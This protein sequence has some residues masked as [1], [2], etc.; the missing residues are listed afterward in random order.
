MKTYRIKTKI[1]SLLLSFIPLC[2]WAN[3][4]EID[5]ELKV[6]EEFTCSVSSFLDYSKWNGPRHWRASSWLTIVAEG[7][8]YCKIRADQYVSGTLQVVCDWQEINSST[9]YE[10][11]RRVT[12]NITLKKI[13]VSS[14]SLQPLIAIYADESEN[15]TPG[16]Q[17]MTIY[18]SNATV[19]TISWTSTN[20]DVATI[21]NSGHLVGKKPGTTTIYCMVNGDV[22][23]NDATVQVQEPPFQFNGFSIADQSNNVETKPTITATYSLDLTRSGNFDQIALTDEQGKKVD[24]TVS[25]NGKTLSFTPTKHLQP[26]SAYTL[27]IPKGAVKN[28]WGTDYLFEQKVS[29]ATA[30]WQR[31]TLSVQPEA[32]FLTIGDEIKLSC[33]EADATIYYSTDGSDPTTRYETPILFASDMV[34]RAIAKKDGYYDS[35]ELTKEY[36]KS[37]EIA[38]HYPTDDAPFYNYACVIPSITYTYA[39]EQGDAFGNITLKDDEGEQLS[40]QLLTQDKTL[41]IVP[42]EPL[43]NGE[44]YTLSM[45]EGA[46]VVTDRGEESQAL[47]WQIATGRYAT[48]VSTGGPELMAALKT[49]GSLWTWGRRLTE[50]N[51]DNG[52]YSYAAQ[53]VLGNFVAG[54]VTSVSSGYTHHALLKRDGTLWMWG[55]QLCGEFGNGTREASATPIYIMDGVKHVSCGLQTTAIVKHDGTLWMCGRNDL[56]QIDDSRTVQPQW[57]KV[58]DD[59][60]DVSLSWGKMVFTKSNGESETRTW[61]EQIDEQRK[62]AFT[63]TDDAAQLA[64]GWH[65]AV[66]LRNDGSVWTYD[67][68]GQK[69]VIEGRN[70]QTLQGLVL[71]TEE[72]SLEEG[73]TTVIPLRPEPLLA[74][75]SQLEWSTDNADVAS[76]TDQGLVTATGNG[77]TTLTATIGDAW[78]HQFEATCR[79]KVGDLSGIR[80]QTTLSWQMRVTTGHHC[81]YVE[82]V[83]EGQAVAVYSAS[84]RQLFQGNMTGNKMQISLTT[85]GIYL[86]RS[87]QTAKKVVV[88]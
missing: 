34:L 44:I 36:L 8:T 22:R 29:F 86:V 62:P 13:D 23:S 65:T 14:V 35:D 58:M 46:I 25:I 19:E 31:M 27:T 51:A 74:D 64:Y 12:W 88:R 16:S 56:G 66:V 77:E 68:D 53:S 61:D 47:Q 24:G 33:S 80:E 79:I 41:Y 43:Q 45:P 84:G 20:T 60:S 3:Y 57:V 21:S 5:K 63:D 50:A 17:W 30:D 75:Y 69:E 2:T 48:M 83:P 1:I 78:G 71:S 18:P 26:L 4:E 82:G 39:I 32:T 52:S 9:Q 11:T 42:D 15:I 37:V 6:G 67:E 7:S 59:V 38:E 54:E 72:L 70:P 55:R 76:V 28:K 87:A 40:C 10:I 73:R 81:L 85:G 49:D